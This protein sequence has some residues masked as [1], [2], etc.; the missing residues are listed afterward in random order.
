MTDISLF[1][2]FPQF[3]I[4]YLSYVQLERA[5]VIMSRLGNSDIKNEK[6]KKISATLQ[7]YTID[8]CSFSL[9]PGLCFTLTFHSV[10]GS[11]SPTRFLPRSITRFAASSGQQGP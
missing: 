8:L 10:Q 9:P 6:L 11:S 3:C 7:E 1:V 4:P 2:L 5:L